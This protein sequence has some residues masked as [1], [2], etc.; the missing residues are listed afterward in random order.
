MGNRISTLALVAAM[1]AATLVALP[2][3]AN[4]QHHGHRYGH[5]YGHGYGHRYGHG[6]GH[7]YGTYSSYGFEPYRDNYGSVRIEVEPKEFRDAAQVF[8][9]GAHVGTV[10]DFDGVFQR[11]RL[12]PGQYEVEIRLDGYR[13]FRR[14][15]FVSRGRTYGI[16]HRIGPRVAAEQEEFD[17]SQGQTPAPARA[18]PTKLPSSRATATSPARAISTTEASSRADRDGHRWAHFDS[19]AVRLQVRPNED[20]AQVYVDG[21]H[22]GVVDD[23]D[24]VF[25]KLDLPAGGHEIEVRL[26]GYRTFRQHVFIS[27]CQTRKLRHRMEPVGPRI[28]AQQFQPPES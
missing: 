2:H 19:G 1:A 20:E 21:A 6:Y 13:T 23:F 22:A 11:L 4:A 5:G 24:G 17:S 9:D 27:P 16:R 14:Q 10:D 3:A 28:A 26:A 7:G 12:S 15:I 8:V 25:Q 18:R